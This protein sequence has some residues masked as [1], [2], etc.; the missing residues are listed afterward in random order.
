MLVRMEDVTT[1]GIGCI[2]TQE[3]TWQDGNVYILIIVVA[4]GLETFVE[5]R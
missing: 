2:E 1:N 5:T 3:N 4:I